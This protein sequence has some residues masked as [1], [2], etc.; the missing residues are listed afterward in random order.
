MVGAG[1]T[2]VQIF[3]Q[4]TSSL[5]VTTLAGSASSST[6]LTGSPGRFGYIY[7]IAASGGTLYVIDQ[8]GGFVRKVDPSTGVVSAYASLPSWQYPTGVAIGS[9]GMAYVTLGNGVVAIDASGNPTTVAG[10][11]GHGLLDGVATSALFN[12]PNGVAINPSSSGNPLVYIADPPNN[13]IRMLSTND[14]T[15]ATIAGS[16]TAG[17]T[18]IQG[19]TFNNPMGLAFDAANNLYIADSLNNAIRKYNQQGHVSTVAGLG[20]AGAGYVDG[21]ASLA[22]FNGPIAVAVDGSGNLYIADQGNN[23]IRIIDALGQNVT[24]FAGSGLGGS[25]NVDGAAASAHIPSPR[26]LVFSGGVLY[27]TDSNNF[28]RTVQPAPSPPPTPPSP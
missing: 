27:F 22:Q 13:C 26:G 4:A 16:G 18:N 2:A 20:S 9:N 21:A 10:Q 3:S 25:V 7:G 23:A 11:A 1:A 12:T 8:T 15:V 28:L 5:V 6:P 17:F 19:G 24:T 14:G